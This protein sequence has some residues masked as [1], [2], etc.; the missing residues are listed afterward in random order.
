MLSNKAILVSKLIFKH[1]VNQSIRII[2]VLHSNVQCKVLMWS[3]ML[4]FNKPRRFVFPRK[5]SSQVHHV[6]DRCWWDESLIF[7][8]DVIMSS[9]LIWALSRLSIVDGSTVRFNLLDMVSPLSIQMSWST[10]QASVVAFISSLLFSHFLRRI[11]HLPFSCPEHPSVTIL[12]LLK[13]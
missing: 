9:S 4:L 5:M 8:Q 1:K 7:S 13:R 2:H 11:R 12:A 3:A 6:Y 10:M